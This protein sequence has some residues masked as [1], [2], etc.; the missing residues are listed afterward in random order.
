MKN[1]DMTDV[2][3]RMDHLVE[4][5]DTWNEGLTIAENSEKKYSTPLGAAQLVEL[6]HA[7]QL[8]WFHIAKD[9]D[10]FQHSTIIDRLPKA[11]GIIGGRGTELRQKSIEEIIE[12]H[13]DIT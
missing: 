4:L 2:G 7:V 1:L 10:R 3:T 8:L 9:Y 11:V 6:K 5:Y 13:G 12:S